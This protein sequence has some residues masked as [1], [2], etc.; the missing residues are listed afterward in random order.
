MR[1]TRLAAALLSITAVAAAQSANSQIRLARPAAKQ[2]VAAARVQ[3]PQAQSDAVIEAA[4]RAKLAKSKIAADKFQVRVQGGVATFEGRTDVIQHKGV[5]TRL[6]RA[7]GAISVNN[8]IQS[9]DA[10]KQKAAANLASGRRR[11]QIKR[12]DARSQAT[13][14]TQNK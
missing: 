4:I 8:H 12:G 11:A 7:A 14:Q 3:K 13:A 2:P 6:A 10:A 1:T 9:S 5:A